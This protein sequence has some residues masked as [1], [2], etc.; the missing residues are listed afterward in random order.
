MYMV[1]WCVRVHDWFLANGKVAAVYGE[2]REAIQGSRIESWV[3]W[4]YEKDAKEEKMD[5]RD[6]K[7]M[8]SI[9]NLL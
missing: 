2:I 6:Y 9:S 5:R 7:E 4:T 8:Q 3:L 1:Q